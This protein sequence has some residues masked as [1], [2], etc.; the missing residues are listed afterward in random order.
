MIGGFRSSARKVGLPTD[1]YAAAPDR[2]HWRRLAGPDALKAFAIF[3]VVLAHSHGVFGGASIG[4]WACDSV[5]RF[6]VPSFIIMWAFFF[7]RGYARQLKASPFVRGRF[8]ALFLPY[9]FWTLLYTGPDI[10]RDGP[11]VRE[12]LT[13]YWSGY[14]WAGQYFFIILFQLIL[15]FGCL[16][17]LTVRHLKWILVGGVAFYSVSVWLL[18]TSPT[19]RQLWSR[20]FLYWVPCVQLG[21]WLARSNGDGAMRVAFP[22]VLA[23]LVALAAEAVA[24]NRHGLPPGYETP[25]A[26]L[27]SAAMVIFFLNGDF[28]RAGKPLTGFSVLSYVGRNSMGVFC[29]NPLVAWVLGWLC[30]KFPPAMLSGPLGFVPSILSAIAVLCGSLLGVELIRRVGLRRVVSST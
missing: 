10:I 9:A 18:T 19:A 8:F 17:V 29:V 14:G 11:S 25:A 1:G 20:P 26:W 21:V 23:A 16:R 15:L 12:L 27:A 6:S 2:K 3:G 5:F 22:T 30:P 13:G 4:D 24:F 7:E 28:G